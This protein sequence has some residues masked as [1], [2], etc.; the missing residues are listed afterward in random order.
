MKNKIDANY[1]DKQDFSSL[2]KKNNTKKKVYKTS[3]KR[4]T[5]NISFESYNEATKL[6]RIMG[7]GYQ[8]VLKAAIF[9]G[10]K[11]LQKIAD[12][13]KQKITKK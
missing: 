10:L 9:H 12:Q 6:D 2:M 3:T 7:M 13:Q 11:D 8:N 4:V 1:Y 5:M